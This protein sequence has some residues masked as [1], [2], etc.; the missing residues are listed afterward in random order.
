M[1]CGMWVCFADGIGQLS[2]EWAGES[3]GK[4]IERVGLVN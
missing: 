1:L 4:K 2:V 3:E